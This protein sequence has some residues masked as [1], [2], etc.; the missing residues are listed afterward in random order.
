[1]QFN[2]GWLFAVYDDYKGAGGAG[3]NADGNRLIGSPRWSVS[4]GVTYDVPV[5]IPGSLRVGLNAQW[6][7]G[8]VTSATPAAGGQNNIPSQGF[9]NGV[10]TWTSPDPHWAVSLSVRNILNSDKPVGA[11]YT[12]S[13]GVYYQNFPDPRTA[14]V[15]LKYAL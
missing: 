9:L 5:E 7:S 14:L 10:A 8:I 13:T 3:V 11:T 15:T 6:Q 4:S 1:V 12:P 2:V